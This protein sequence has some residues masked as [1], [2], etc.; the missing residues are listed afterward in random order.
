MSPYFRILILLFTVPACLF[1]Q[2]KPKK[3]KIEFSANSSEIDKSIGNGVKRLIGNV[4]FKHENVVMFCDSA[5]L[6]DNNTLIAYKNVHIQQGDSIHVYG[7]VLKY[8]GNSKKAEII[9]NIRMTDGEMTLTTEQLTYDMHTNIAQYSG[10][11]K[12]I[13][14][15]NVLTSQYGYYHSK[16]KLLYFKK[17]VVLTNPEYVMNSD[18]LKYDTQSR[19]AYFSGPTYIRS[20]Q[21]LIYCEDGYYDTENDLSRFSKNSYIISGKQTLKGDSLFYDR[22]KAYGLAKGNITVIDSGERLTIS[23][24]RAEY[25]QKKEISIIT[26]KPLLSQVNDNDTLFL[27]ADT[28]RASYELKDSAGKKYIDY[29]KRILLCYNHVKF[30]QPD[31]QGKCDSLAYTYSDST[32][33]LYG[34]PVLWSDRQQITAGQINILISKGEIK[35]M[36][37][38]QS[39]FI[40]GMEDTTRF[41]QIKGK[42]MKAYFI[43][44]ELHKIKVEGN[45]QT[46]YYAKDKGK[47]FGVNK[48]ECSDLLI[49]MKNNEIS[50]ITF[51]QNPEATLTPA[52]DV[53]DKEMRLKGFLW[54]G[55]E[56]PKSKK[57]IFK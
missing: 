6:F 25:Y 54:R 21:D 40:A 4:R 31:L 14:K 41:N 16:S 7:D 19:I 22:K 28:L 48:A 10:S 3:K 39:A 24:Q 2:Q 38:L 11:G 30:F 12:I 15:D 9:K 23:G 37:M 55:S 56:R 43:K 29:N 5:Y 27:H 33:K 53:K 51:I 47:I 34:M 26:G 36:D 20:N 52:K 49:Y 45:G 44:N 46:I 8:N 35:S 50:R 18:T 32:M 1:A 17:N 13:N 57:D 42:N